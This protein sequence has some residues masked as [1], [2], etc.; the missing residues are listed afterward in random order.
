MHC[1]EEI[2][3]TQ[4]EAERDKV[5]SIRLELGARQ[6][7]RVL[8]SAS[9]ASVKSGKGRVARTSRQQT[10]DSLCLASVSPS[11]PPL[12]PHLCPQLRSDKKGR[13]CEDKSQDPGDVSPEAA[14]TGHLVQLVPQGPN[15]HLAHIPGCTVTPCGWGWRHSGGDRLPCHHP[16]DLSWY[17]EP[18]ESRIQ[19]G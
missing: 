13:K 19:T 15:G 14:F 18:Q 6:L 12:H 17:R 1:R 10:A 3:H 7:A 5:G 4:E 16:L 8:G 2:G 9:T 11:L